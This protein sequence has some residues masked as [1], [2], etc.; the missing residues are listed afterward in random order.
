MLRNYNYGLKTIDGFQLD[1]SFFSR[2]RK[3]NKLD[4]IDKKQ[5]EIFYYS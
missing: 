3:K 2:A 1:A 5:N 4:Q